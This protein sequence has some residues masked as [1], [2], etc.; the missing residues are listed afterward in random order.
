MRLTLR[1]LLAY[2]YNVLEPAEA[3]E[4]AGKVQ[5]STVA[6]GLVQRIRGISHKLRMSA[7]RIDAKGLTDDANNV[8][9]Y[10]DNN[11]ADDRV[12]DFERTCLE[13]DMHL[14]EVASSYQILTMV[15]GKPADVPQ[16]L[17]ERVYGLPAEEADVH[18]EPRDEE[19]AEKSRIRSRIVKAATAAVDAS[20]PQAE[21]KTTSTHPVPEVPDYLKQGRSRYGVLPVIAASLLAFLVV[22][23]LIRMLGPY[24]RTNPALSWMY[25]SQPVA[26]A[27]TNQNPEPVTPQQKGDGSQTDE[28]KNSKGKPDDTPEVIAPDVSEEKGAKT[29]PTPTVERKVAVPTKPPMV[30]SPSEPVPEPAKTVPEPLKTIPEPSKGPKI[31]VKTVPPVVVKK[32]GPELGRYTSDEQVL[33][34]YD[35][36]EM[37]WKMVPTRDLIF[38]GERLQVLPTYRPQIALS[39]GAQITFA[40]E[41]QVQLETAKKAGSSEMTV[42][43]GRMVVVTV[44]MP[45]VP[46]E[47]D[48]SGLKGTLILSDADAG[49]AIDSRRYLPPGSDPENDAAYGVVEIFTT[50]G[51]ATW[52]A[53]GAQVVEIPAGNLLTYVLGTEEVEPD[54]AG[55]F[56]APAWIDA[57]SLTSIDRVTSLNM[58]K[59][60]DPEKPLE[61]RLQELLVDPAVDVRALAARCLCYLDQFEPLLKDLGNVQ[62]KA[63]WG[64]EI[65]ALHRALSRSP[66]TA[67]KVREAAAAVRVKQGKDIYRLLWGYSPEQ[68]A[69]IGGAE[70][71][72]YLESPELDVRVL[73]SDNLLRITGALQSYNPAKRPDENKLA[74]N[75]WKSRIKEGTIAYKLPPAPFMD[76]IPLAEKP[77]PA[78]GKGK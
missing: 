38:A 42:H 9:E 75:K 37:V 20:R 68:L 15:L 28:T 5:E 43:Y 63:F 1:A 59:M 50:S 3:E 73:A 35:A 64:A 57:A 44:G 52:Q 61:V 21:V 78:A 2:L 60:L 7:P 17:R 47:L 41:S 29:S 34:R 45:G 56:K 23:A 24:D 51:R 22:A 16:K 40:G 32:D 8:A 25:S 4:F 65:D 58:L 27:G 10:L 46:L 19:S 74:L 48:L 30:E 71:V 76:R 36:K 69:N 77:A 53:E 54:L 26:D 6:T 66:E 67:V 55:P 62:Q 70:L 49:V 13:S 12:A 72:E 33:S 39:S 31:P 18:S 11:L 14:A